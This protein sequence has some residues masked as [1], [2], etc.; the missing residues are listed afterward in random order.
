MAKMHE[1]Y[2]E[3]ESIERSTQWII[4]NSSDL[5][6]RKLSE[7]VSITAD[8]GLTPEEAQAFWA[9][10]YDKAVYNSVYNR[11]LREARRKPAPTGEGWDA[12]HQLGT[13]KAKTAKK[14]SSK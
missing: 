1:L 9:R 7:L 14:G 6:K 4:D 13:V 8:Y 3:M 12:E 5:Q 2:A 11:R 10:K